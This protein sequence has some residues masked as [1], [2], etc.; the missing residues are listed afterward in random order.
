MRLSDLPN[1]LTILRLIFVPILLGTC[2]LPVGWSNWLGL[3]IFVAAGITDYLDGALARR[4]NVVSEF[5]RM[6][7]PIADKLMIASVLLLLLWQGTAPLIPA[8]VIIG[9]ELVVSGL[10]EYLALVGQKLEVTSLAK[11]K[12]ALQFVALAV[13]LAVGNENVPSAP[14]VT[15]ELIGS[16]LLWVAAL[17]TLATGY[18]YWAKARAFDEKQRLEARS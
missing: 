14:G 18:D 2:L 6:L 15:L 10:R 7:D 5:G 3:S 13:L 16:S 17:L 12:T 9:R 8:I 1:G 11:W 4:L